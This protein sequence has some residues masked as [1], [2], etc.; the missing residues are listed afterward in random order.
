MVAALGIV[1]FGAIART[2]LD[3]LAADP[4]ETLRR[5]VVL[6]RKGREDAVRDGV[7]RYPSLAPVELLVVTDAAALIASRPDLA[8]ESA[9]QGA[10]VEHVVPILAAGIETLIVSAGALA[11]PDT[12][13]AVRAAAA[14]GGTRAKILAGAIGGTDILGAFRRAGLE[15]VVYTGRKHPRAW[16]GSPAEADHDL[17]ALCEPTVLFE[18]NA[19]DA[20]LRFPKNANV[21]ATVALAGLGFERTRVRLLA[22]PGVAGNT[23]EIEARSRIG[24]LR[25]EIVGNALSGNARTSASAAYSA[26]SDIL[27]RD[28]SLIV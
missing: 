15:G 18:G 6:C 1:G 28:A 21:A 27:N 4:P 3:G 20:A 17:L 26:L 14:R 13:A 2:V 25:V 22:D 19:R 16:L 5:L 8:V 12:L 10:V 11:A 7:G 9:G 23:H 24:R